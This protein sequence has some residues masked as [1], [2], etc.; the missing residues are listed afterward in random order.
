MKTTT[1]TR[2]IFA[3]ALAAFLTVFTGTNLLAQNFENCATGTYTAGAT[4]TIIMKNSNGLFTDETGDATGANALGYDAAG[5]I[6]GIVVWEQDNAQNVQGRFYTDLQTRG[7]GI[8]T[9]STA[10]S[11]GTGR[12]EIHVRGTYTPNQDGEAN[13]ER[14]YAGT[15]F[16]YDGSGDQTIAGEANGHG[17]GGNGEGYAS[18]YLNNSSANPIQLLSGETVDV[19]DDFTHTGNPFTNNGTFNIIAGLTPSV[20]THSSDQVITNANGAV[21]N[22][23]D[24]GT[25]T[26]SAEFVNNAGTAG[27]NGV[28]STA[29]ILDFN[30]DYTNT[31]GE[32]TLGDG[33]TMQVAANFVK[34]DGQGTFSFHENSNFYYDGAVQTLL[35]TD[36]DFADA[37]ASGYYGGYGNVFLTGSGAKSTTAAT[38]EFN[39]AGNF[40]TDVE[41]DMDAGNTGTGAAI[42]M[43]NDDGTETVTYSN[44]TTDVEVRGRFQHQNLTTGQLY[45]YNNEFTTMQFSAATADPGDYVELNIRQATDPTLAQSGGTD[46]YDVTTDV[47]RFIELNYVG[48]HRADE[49][50]VMWESGDEDAT[51]AGDRQLFRYVEAF[52]ANQEYQKLIRQGAQYNRTDAGSDPRLLLYEGELAG[53]DNGIDMNGDAGDADVNSIAS[54]SQIIITATPQIF[55]SEEDGRWTNPNTWDVG[56][57][58][59]ANDNVEIE[60]LVYVGIDGPAWGTIGGAP[61]TPENNTRAEVDHY[62]AGVNAANQ[63]QIND[64]GAGTPSALLIGNEDNGAGYVFSTN[65]NGAIGGREAGIVNNNANVNA[66]DYEDKSQAV[67]GLQGLILTDRTDGG[68]AA[69]FTATAGFRQVINCGHVYNYGIIEI[70]E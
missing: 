21:L 10:N 70:G 23:S 66:G 55:I 9:F 43:L 60:T 62:G 17:T 57:V 28:F 69:Q 36:A 4:G 49:L 8:K 14:R 18:L 26:F 67:T 40:D 35:L 11:V 32:L 13:E 53:T 48:T 52:A 5:Q 29:G 24:E 27:G 25:F 65:L 22:Y 50:N 6:D 33:A 16:Y 64:M 30:A 46:V 68:G 34:A 31:S 63:I 19:N 45:T 7:E 47:R 41:V 12:N 56:Q 38:G 1:H 58:P 51:F 42:V 20:S 3:F 15:I 37:P 2:A 59:T 44:A 39:I 54:G 61:D